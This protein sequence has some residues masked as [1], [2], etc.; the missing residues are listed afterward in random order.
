MQLRPCLTRAVFLVVL[1]HDASA[2]EP[3]GVT[4]NRVWPADAAVDKISLAKSRKE[5]CARTPSR[6]PQ[7]ILRNVEYPTSELNRLPGGDG[8]VLG[9]IV[10]FRS[11]QKSSFARTQELCQSSLAAQ[12]DSGSPD[13]KCEEAWT[14]YWNEVAVPFA[15]PLACCAVLILIWWTCCFVACCRCCRRMVCCQEAREPIPTTRTY[16]FVGVVLW[17]GASITQVALCSSLI[18]ANERLHHAINWNSCVAHTFADEVIYG[19]DWFLGSEPTV[20]RLTNIA[21]TLDVDSRTMKT[22]RSVLSASAQFA[23]KHRLLWRRLQHLNKTLAEAGSGRRS[24]DHRCVFCNL[25]LGQGSDGPEAAPPWRY[26]R[27]GLLNSISDQVASS[28]SSAM[29]HIREF[30]TMRLTGAN[31]TDLARKMKLAKEAFTLFDRGLRDALP[32]IWGRLRPQVDIVENMRY[33]LFIIVCVLSSVGAFTGWLAFFITR[34]RLQKW[35]NDHKRRPPSG[36]QHCCSWCCGFVHGILA[37]LLGGSLLF[38]AAPAGEACLFVRQDLLSW[39]GI[40]K[41]APLLGFVKDPAAGISASAVDGAVKLAQSCFAQNRSGK[42]LE[43]FDLTSD[44][45][46]FEPELSQAFYRMDSRVSEPPVGV[47]TQ[48]LLENLRLAAEEYGSDF[49]LDPVSADP[50]LS[51]GNDSLG[52]LELSANVKNLLLGSSLVA[53]NTKAP[54]TVTVVTGLNVFAELIAGPGQYTFLH[55]TAGGGFVITPFR[56]TEEELS[57]LPLQVGNALRYAKN[58]ERLLASNDSLP[59]DVLQASG[60]VQLRRCGVYEF[61]AHVMSEVRLIKETVADTIRE[62]EAVQ[63]LFVQVL[64]SQLLP[65]LSAVRGLTSLNSCSAM[66]RRVEELDQSFCDEVATTLAR[67]SLQALAQFVAAIVGIFVQYKA[68]RR[69]KDNKILEEELERFEKNLAKHMRELAQVVVKNPFQLN[70]ENKSNKT[71][72]ADEGDEEREDEAREEDD[73]ADNIGQQDD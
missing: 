2:N 11:K 48:D 47:T 62:A 72:D 20:E 42:M 60:D 22:L 17:A 28:S 69:L 19:A 54:D 43:A 32:N 66:W 21:S 34:V 64:K 10:A 31:L 49:V 52:T 27:N 25:A 53:D 71:P 63:S 15:I 26:P 14:S 6:S 51:I 33:T 59:C 16:A 35:E 67:G 55:G 65:M 68:W 40:E 46:S 29:V 8:S 23:E 13:S 1:A 61:Q 56:P 44:Y 18:E 57:S 24:F 3:K 58:K 12:A 50:S 39:G 5:A 30:S 7:E 9:S 41:Y 37:L 4:P 45:L 73:A 36:K 70:E 38:V